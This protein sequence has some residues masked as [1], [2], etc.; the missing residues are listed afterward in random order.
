MS[1]FTQHVCGSFVLIFV[2]VILSLFIARLY[3]VIWIYNLSIFLLLDVWVVPILWLFWTQLL[4]I[5]VTSP[6][7]DMFA[8][9]NGISCSQGNLM[10]TF[11]WNSHISRVAVPL[12]TASHVWGFLDMG[13]LGATLWGTAT[14]KGTWGCLQTES[15]SFRWPLSVPISSPFPTGP[16]PPP[17]ISTIPLLGGPIFLIC[18]CH[19]CRVMFQCR[20]LV[21]EGLWANCYSYTTSLPISELVCLGEGAVPGP[22]AQPSPLRPREGRPSRVLLHSDLCWE[23]T[24]V[25]VNHRV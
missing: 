5:H 1:F 16:T 21:G 7:V 6:F 9:K 17:Q 3:S 20:L 25:F 8:S 10:C 11:L 2:S 23:H 12:T 15:H 18:P 24:H 19:W 22:V 13:F 14:G 4:W